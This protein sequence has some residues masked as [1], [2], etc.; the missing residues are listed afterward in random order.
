[1]K[2]NEID[3]KKVLLV[4]RARARLI[5][6]IFITAVVIA[7]IVTYLSP[8]MYRAA[9]TLNFEFTTNPVDTRGRILSDETYLS[10]QIDIIKRSKIHE[11]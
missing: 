2:H 5:T 1:M 10:T 8:K 3:I 9:S 11:K 6:A 4:F 7:G